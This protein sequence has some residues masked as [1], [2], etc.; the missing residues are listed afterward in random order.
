MI[1]KIILSIFAVVAYSHSQTVGWSKVFDIHSINSLG[2]LSQ[3]FAKDSDGNI[4]VAV[5]EFDILKLYKIDNQ[6]TIL[7]TFNTNTECGYFS[8]IVTTAENNFALVYDNTPDEI[9]SSYKLFR[10]NNFFEN[11]QQT[12]LNFSING[13]RYFS[14]LFFVENTMYFSVLLNNEQRFYY[15]NESNE[16]VLKHLSTLGGINYENYIPLQNENLII[17]YGSGNNHLIRCVSSSSGQ[18]VW[19]RSFLNNDINTLQLN[20]VTT[21]SPDEIIY[22]AGLE[23]TWNA[24]N[25]LDVIKLRKIEKNQGEIILS[26]TLIPLNSC[27]QN[28][29]DLKFNPFNNHCYISYRSCFPDQKIVV[30]ELDSDFNQISQIEFPVEYDEL[31]SGKSS[32]LIIRNN[33]SIVLLYRSF[34]NSS[35]NGNLYIVSLDPSLNVNGSTDLNIEP[36]NSSE[37]FSSYKFINDGNLVIVGVLPN[38]KPAILLEEVQHYIAMIDVDNVLNTVNLSLNE[39]LKIYP[40]PA[41]TTLNFDSYIP[42]EEVHIV[43]ATGKKVLESKVINNILDVSI[44]KSGTY[45]IEALDE[46]KSLLLAKFIKK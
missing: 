36:K 18:L 29:D 8:Q 30:V 40:N 38:T 9:N 26:N 39:K 24:G 42:I 17:D 23:R 4:I 2:G 37:T 31:E 5:V 46:N 27:T 10:F 22:N 34:K 33:G 45:I 41:L 28:I 3:N 43:D 20:Y 1:K 44:L 12:T 11:I 35:E 6:G 25:G 13:Y 32:S 15:L 7:N 21:V 19:N 14:S 16:L